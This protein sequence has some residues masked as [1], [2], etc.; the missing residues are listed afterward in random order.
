M[1]NF[2]SQLQDAAQG[3]G[4]SSSLS[5]EKLAAAGMVTCIVVLVL[6]LLNCFFGLK[7]LKIWTAL[8]GLLI[9]FAAG[10]GI[11]SAF[12]VTTMVAVIIGVV[13][14]IVL[15]ILGF[16]IYLAGVFVFSGVMGFSIVL[17]IAGTATTT[18]FI[19][20]AVVGLIIALLALKFVEPMVI[21]ATGLQGGL[22]AGAA[23]CALVS[24]P[25]SYTYLIIGV[26]LAVI[27]IVVQFI[28]D[29]HKKVKMHLKQADKVRKE[30]S[31]ENEVEKLRAAL[32]NTDKI[33]EDPDA[34]DYYDED[35]D[36]Y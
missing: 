18:I 5:P 4:T 1:E 8:L 19:V 35:E 30:N 31:T 33:K 9:G 27:G 26:I 23:I 17:A 12:G 11:S 34:D 3:M 32:D 6:S 2:M 28:M 13:A 10:F 29:S 36:E 20:A 15:A 14:G 21:V 22:T 7:L 25:G 16:W 24:I